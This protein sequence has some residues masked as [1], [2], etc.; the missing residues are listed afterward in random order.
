M[1]VIESRLDTNTDSYR[2][3]REAILALLA[4]VRRLEEAVR[5]N[6]ERTKEK[7][8]RRGQLLPRERL[9]ALLDRDAPFLELSSLA[10]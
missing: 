8:R 10:G 6:S 4:E 3:N 5:R 1:P 7:F 9:A 2:S